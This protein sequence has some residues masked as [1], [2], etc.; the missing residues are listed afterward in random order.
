MG[1]LRRLG[2]WLLHR[3]SPRPIR[4]DISRLAPQEGDAGARLARETVIVGGPLK[5]DHRRL[6]TRDARLLPKP[7][8]QKR[9][10]W[11]GRRRKVMTV[12][13][14]KR[15]FGATLRTRNRGLRDLAPDEDQ[16]ARYGLPV[17]RTEEDLAAALG[18]TVGGLRAFSIHRQR[19]RTEHYLRFAVPKRSGGERIILAPKKRLKAV[20]RRLLNLLVSRLPVSEHAHG[21]RPGRSVRTAAAPH[22]G[23]RVVLRL[24]L[25]DFFPSVT[26]ARVRG[27]LVALGYGYPVATTLAVLMTEAERQP[28]EIDG[29]LYHV[30]VT[31]R[32][33][34]QGAPT[35]PGLCNA[36]LLRLDRRLAGL[37][38]CHGFAYT[39]YADDL[40]FSGDGD[41]KAVGALLAAAG[42]IVAAEGFR[43]NREKTRVMSLGR[44]QEVCGVTVNRDLGLSRRERRRLRAELHHLAQER[45]AGRPDPAGEERARGRLAYLSMLNPEQARTIERGAEAKG[46]GTAIDPQTVPPRR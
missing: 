28:V 16:L 24:D 1:L 20:Q 11:T 15:L 42:R 12:G 7:P 30:P 41:R 35:S 37:A 31:P 40:T 44:R 29:V 9:S 21:F 2:L 14:A 32:S 8:D 36:V 39:R 25:Q 18:L 23:R 38:S 3:V 10:A 19:E 34:P 17:W 33:C 43:M 22:V 4:R 5:P 13:E 6:A 27:L 26:F 46:Q 45:A